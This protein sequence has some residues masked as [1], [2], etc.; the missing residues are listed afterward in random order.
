VRLTDV[1]TAI[2]IVIRI[3]DAYQD[4]QKRREQEKNAPHDQECR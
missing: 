3:V 1:L 4:Q 2:S